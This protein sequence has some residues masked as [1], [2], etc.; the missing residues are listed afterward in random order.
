MAENQNNPEWPELRELTKEQLLRSNIELRAQAARLAQDVKELKRQL[1]ELG[2]L[3]KAGSDT[4]RAALNLMEDAVSARRAEQLENQ[5]RRRAEEALRDADRRK[6]EFLA[7][8]AHELRNPLASIA[9]ASQLLIMPGAESHAEF[10]KELIRRQVKHLA[11]LI[12]D[13]LDISRITRGKIELRLQRIDACAVIKSAVEV[14]RPLFDERRHE[15]TVSMTDSDL[16]CEADP[17]R[18][19]QMLVN[20]L[21]NAAKY[22]DPGGH[23]SLIARQNGNK[24]SLKVKD[25]GVGIPPARIPAMFELFVQG[26]QNLAR[27]EGGLGIGLA[28][29]KRIAEL[30][31]GTASAFSEGPGKGSEF[32]VRL[33]V[34]AP[35]APSAPAANEQRGLP[36]GQTVRVLIIE[37]NPQTA[38]S[39]S[40]LLR[41]CGHEIRTAQ[42]GAA[43]ITEALAFRP[44]CILLDIGLPVMDGYQVAD[45]LRRSGFA[46]TRI[47]AISGYGHESDRERSR[48][49][50]IDHHLVKPLDYNTLVSLIGQPQDGSAQAGATIGT[51]FAEPKEEGELRSQ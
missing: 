48:S 18:L 46:D 51:T 37:D 6:D 33:P 34:A 9:T 15:L 13:L 24:I 42:D 12:E 19:E 27:V 22:T 3:N 49:A 26:D 43:A 8:L 32:T 11:R 10:A 47:I 40:R 29:V 7:M 38:D 23:I 20:L 39:L 21:N 36:T 28:I 30:H 25:D 45:Q 31:G 17:I 35:P 16:W 4:R 44:E 41:L 14:I 1:L 50:G 5:I 2:A